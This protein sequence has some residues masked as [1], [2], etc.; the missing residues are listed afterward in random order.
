MK[1]LALAAVL[2]GCAA[3][4][5]PFTYDTPNGPVT[6]HPDE[7]CPDTRIHTGCTMHTSAGW[8]VYYP[9]GYPAMRQHEQDHSQ[10]LVHGR[11]VCT[12]EECC[13]RIL[14]AG[15]THWTPGHHIC[16]TRSWDDPT[17]TD[18]PDYER[19]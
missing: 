13:A 16:T 8:Q 19:P 9:R 17:R 7:E 14:A 12:P 4:P 1:C 6:E 11:W 15:L 2:C 3:L 5:A 10:G 18:P